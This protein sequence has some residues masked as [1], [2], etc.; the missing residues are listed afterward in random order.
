MAAPAEFG[1]RFCYATLRGF[2]LDNRKGGIWSLVAV[3]HASDSIYLGLGAVPWL[4]GGLYSLRAVLP[5]LDFGRWKRGYVP[6]A[7]I[8][9]L[10]CLWSGFW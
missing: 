10:L 1:Q 3:A 2:A 4:V 8:G 7:F 5:M 6:Y 9:A